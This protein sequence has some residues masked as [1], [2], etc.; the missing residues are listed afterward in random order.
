MVVCLR[1]RACI[2]VNPVLLGI[3]SLVVFW[4]FKNDT[5]SELKKKKEKKKKKTK[6]VRTEFWRKLYRYKMMF[7]YALKNFV[8]SFSWKRPKMKNHILDY[9]LLQ[10]LY[11]AKFWFSSCG[12]KCSWSRRLQGSSKCNISRKK[13]RIKS[14]FCM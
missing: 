13:E 11:L 8:I 4:N 10:T 7:L 5:S 12:P 3:C 9:I 6:L 2:F 14:I 1:I